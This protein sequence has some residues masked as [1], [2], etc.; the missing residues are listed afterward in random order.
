[1]PSINS[2]Q[3][4][5]YNSRRQEIRSRH[6]SPPNPILHLLQYVTLPN[7]QDH[8][9][10][11][12]KRCCLKLSKKRNTACILFSMAGTS[13]M[14]AGILLAGLSQVLSNMD[15]DKLNPLNHIFGLDSGRYNSF[16]K[17]E[18]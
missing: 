18:N 13:A 11:Q 8:S 6:R 7:I 1:M 17:L 5:N 2:A 16:F 12:S 10:V 3:A 4:K 14:S 15:G 9:A